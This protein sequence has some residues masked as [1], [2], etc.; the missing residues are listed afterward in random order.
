MSW[1]LDAQWSWLLCAC[2]KFEREKTGNQQPPDWLRAKCLNFN[3][4]HQQF[5]CDFAKYFLKMFCKL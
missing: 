5:N 2:V 3:K 1:T 4:K